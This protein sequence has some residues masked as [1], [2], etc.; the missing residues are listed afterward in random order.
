MSTKPLSLI[1]KLAASQKGGP[2][3]ALGKI[4][5]GMIANR[6][7]LKR[8]NKSETVVSEDTKVTMH[9]GATEENGLVGASL[10]L[11][12]PGPKNSYM[13]ARIDISCYLPTKTGSDDDIRATFR[14]VDSLVQAELESQV[15]EAKKALGIE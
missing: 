15:D 7:T 2:G 12:F 8:E 3:L 10:G 11:T 9:P 14:R 13:S 1:P 4:T 6:Q 5:G